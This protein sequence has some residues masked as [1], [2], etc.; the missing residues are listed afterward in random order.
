[1]D[2]VSDQPAECA[3]RNTWTLIMHGIKAKPRVRPKCPA[4]TVRIRCTSR[5]G[6]AEHR[7]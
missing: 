3:S 6:A 2:H 5:I 1:M 7:R 4:R